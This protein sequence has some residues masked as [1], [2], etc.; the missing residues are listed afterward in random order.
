MLHSAASFRLVLERNQK[1]VQTNN[2]NFADDFTLYQKIIVYDGT[3]IRPDTLIIYVQEPWHQKGLA[4]QT[5][6]GAIS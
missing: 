3:S 5:S 2:Y 4:G 1:E 6:S